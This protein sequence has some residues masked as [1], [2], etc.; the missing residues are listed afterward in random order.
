M[1]GNKM[2]KIVTVI[3][4]LTVMATSANACGWGGCNTLWSKPNYGG[5]YSLYSGNTFLG[6]SKPSYGGGSTFYFK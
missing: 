6:Y 5:G 3:G 4:L 1:K 2:K